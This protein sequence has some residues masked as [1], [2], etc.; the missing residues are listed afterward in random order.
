MHDTDYMQ[1]KVRFILLRSYENLQKPENI[2]MP[3]AR[4]VKKI[5]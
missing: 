2:I 1:K 3:D 5:F 4:Q